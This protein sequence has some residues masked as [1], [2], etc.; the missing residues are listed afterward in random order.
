MRF[1]AP[2]LMVAVRWSTVCRALGFDG[3]LRRLVLPA[4]YSGAATS[5]L[6]RTRQDKW[7]SRKE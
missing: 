7:P 3:K 1:L 6:Y 5:V 4:L 2:V